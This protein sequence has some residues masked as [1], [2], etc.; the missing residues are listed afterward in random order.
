LVGGTLAKGNFAEGTASA[1][2]IGALTLNA[3]NST[4]DFG[5]GTVGILS[6]ASL[7]PN[8]FTLKIDNW[9]GTARTVGTASTDRLIFDSD[10]A[11]NLSYFA[12]TGYGP[13]AVEI[14]VG[15]G[16][17]EVTPIPEVSTS[18]VAMVTTLA[19]VARAWQR[20]LRQKRRSGVLGF[21]IR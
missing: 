6:F 15:G 13:G 19:M 21:G 1:V 5:T 11:P 2:G 7:N 12:F 16:F 18:A 8:T 10:Q 20:S 4:I 17:F 3:S 9:T 14:A